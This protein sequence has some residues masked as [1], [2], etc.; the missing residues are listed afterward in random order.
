MLDILEHSTN[1][2]GKWFSVEIPFL[3]S[4]TIFFWFPYLSIFSFSFVRYF[5]SL[6]FI[7][8]V[9]PYGSACSPSFF[10]GFS[11][12]C[13]YLLPYTPKALR[14]TACGILFT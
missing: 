9:L 7:D 14:H 13:L 8:V 12:F 10:P 3:A 4:M 1:P 11:L 5:S 2:G 6:S